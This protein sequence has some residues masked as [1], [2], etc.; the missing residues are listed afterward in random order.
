MRY[1][2]FPDTPDEKVF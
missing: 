2:A 1:S